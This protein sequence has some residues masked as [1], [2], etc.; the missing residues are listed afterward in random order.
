MTVMMMTKKTRQHSK[1]SKRYTL[2]EDDEDNDDPDAQKPFDKGSGHKKIAVIDR[3]DTAA[4]EKEKHDSG[5][6]N[7]KDVNNIEQQEETDQEKSGDAVIGNNRND[8]TATENDRSDQE[9]AATNEADA[10]GNEKRT[11][12]QEVKGTKA[13]KRKCNKKS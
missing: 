3:D 11:A 8:T 4:I 1:R 6:A 13:K 5:K 9:Y 7:N 2:F 10:G 12:D